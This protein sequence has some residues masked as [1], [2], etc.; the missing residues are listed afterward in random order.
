VKP[1]SVIN[2]NIMNVD[3]APTFL[4]LAGIKTPLNMQGYSFANVLK[5][6]TA[7]WQ[8]NKVFYEYYWEAAFPQ[9]P[10]TFAIRTGRFKYIY[11]N[12]VW[13]INELY[14]LQADP[15]EMNNLIRDTSYQQTGIQ[16]RTELFN[17]LEKTGG[18]QIP[19]KKAAGRR[20]D[21][22]YRNTY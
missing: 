1:N 9:T 2:Q 15:Y 11:Y 19:L 5:G 12:G 18:L 3:L 10:T 7:A 16:L 14:D 4:E 13:D 6:D 22:L 20:F 17:W 8:R 21:N